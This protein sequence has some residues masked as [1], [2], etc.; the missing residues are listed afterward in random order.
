[1]YGQNAG[2]GQGLMN[3]VSSIIPTFGRIF[4]VVSSSDAGEERYDRLMEVM[5][6][7]PNGQI[8]LFTSLSDAYT[9]CTSNNNDVILLD[10][11]TTHSLSSGLAITK[12]RV[13]FIGM[14][15]GDRLVQQGAKVQLAT[16]ATTAYVVKNTGVR[17]SFRNIKFIQAATAAT[18]LTVFQE[19]GEGTLFKNCHFQ[20]GVVDNLDQTDAF[21]FVAGSDSATY[22]DCTFGTDTL[23]T[24]A[25]RAVFSIDQVT[26]SQEF[27]SNILR[28]CTFLISSSSDTATHIRLSAIGDILFTNLF[29]RCNFVASVDSAGGAAIAES[30]Q[31]GTGTVKGVLCFS[32]PA[33]FNSTDFATATGGRN[34]AV[35]LVGVVTTAGTGG[36][37]VTPTA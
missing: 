19:G 21:E 4:V 16:A 3:M 24:S 26:A 11:D 20:F 15:G 31:T 6:T 36:I 25:A 5:K 33:T 28:G 27:K 9:A 2:Y 34:T 22:I 1:M 10:A 14:D 30:V 35:Q 23:L 8:R 7:D 37:G 17:N 13:H 18:G 32:H 12:N 29:D